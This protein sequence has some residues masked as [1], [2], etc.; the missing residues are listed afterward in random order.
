M[1]SALLIEKFKKLSPGA[2]SQVEKSIQELLDKESKNSTAENLKP[3]AQFGD[4]KGFVKFIADD[5]DAPLKD[6]KD[7]M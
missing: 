5:F 6:F 4:L 2:Q 7:Y 3:R 1:D